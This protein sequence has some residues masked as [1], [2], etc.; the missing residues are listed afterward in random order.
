MKTYPCTNPECRKDATPV[1]NFGKAVYCICE[2]CGH[3]FTVRNL[4]Q[5]SQ[6]EID[7][8]RAE[9]MEQTFGKRKMRS[10]V[11]NN[12]RLNGKRSVRQ[13]AKGIGMELNTS[14]MKMHNPDSER[15]FLFGGTGILRGRYD[16][17]VERAEMRRREIIIESTKSN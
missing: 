3:K 8:M 16:E 14:H 12:P 17:L 1:C 10:V 4:G 5:A 7:N 9:I 2:H 11:V 15:E 6:E 13:L